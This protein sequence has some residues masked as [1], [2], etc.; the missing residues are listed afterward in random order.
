MTSLRLLAYLMAP[1]IAAASTV[2]R[3]APKKKYAVPWLPPT[4]LW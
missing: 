1:M 4:A 2:T 3:P